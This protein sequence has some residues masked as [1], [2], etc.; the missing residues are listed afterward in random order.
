MKI[1]LF[2]AIRADG[3][4]YFFHHVT[5]GEALLFAQDA[6]IVGCCDYPDTP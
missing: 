4:R 5:L 2:K 1:Y 6:I 3:S